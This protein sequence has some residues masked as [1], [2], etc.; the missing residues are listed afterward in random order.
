VALR[1]GKQKKNPFPNFGMPKASQRRTRLLRLEKEAR[2]LKA[3]G[4]PYAQWARS[5]ILTRLW[6]TDL[7]FLR[8]AMVYWEPSLFDLPQTKFGKV[9]YVPLNEEA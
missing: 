9:Q 5:A 2:L 7:F 6:K 8:W 1:T 3:L 4:Q